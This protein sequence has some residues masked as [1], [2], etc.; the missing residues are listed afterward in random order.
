MYAVLTLKL[1]ALRENVPMDMD[2]DFDPAPVDDTYTSFNSAKVKS[3]VKTEV[4]PMV[5]MS[6]VKVRSL[7]TAPASSQPVNKFLPK[8]EKDEKKAATVVSAPE[9]AGCQG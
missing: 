1:S 9:S 6:Q 2:M 5:E 3:E 8:F 4:K 7:Q